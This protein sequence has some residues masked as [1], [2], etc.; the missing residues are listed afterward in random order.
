MSFET[1]QGMTEKITIN[2]NTVDL[3]YIDYLVSE[4]HYATRTE[5]IKTAVKAQ[6]DKHEFER[7]QLQKRSEESDDDWVIGICR[8]S[9]REIDR[10]IAAGTPKKRLLCVGMLVI[11]PDVT[12]E[13]MTRVYETVKVHGVC[14]ASQEMKMYYQIGR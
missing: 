12:L 3:G 10:M 4:G 6:L 11:G 2:I 8:V 14:K 7:K 5:F 13:N 1:N 9:A